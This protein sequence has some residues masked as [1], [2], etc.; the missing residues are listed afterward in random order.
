MPLFVQA[1]LIAILAGLAQMDSRIFG[2]NLIDRPLVTGSIVGLILGDFQTGIIVGA[3]LE[4]VWL[5]IVNIGGATPPDVISGGILGTAFAI[6]G[7]F[8]TETAIAVA[9]PIALLAQ[10]LG[11][12]IRIINT[13][14]NHRADVHAAKGNDKGVDR[15]LYTG[16]ILFF[17][18]ASVPVFF[19]VFFGAEAVGTLVA[20]I[21]ERILYGMRMSAGILPALGMAILMRFI[22]DKTTA[23]FLFIG[24]VMSAILGMSM[25]SISIVGAAVAYAIFRGSIRQSL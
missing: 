17:L 25:I 12:L 23:P 24:F 5:G 20:A 13:G 16:A 11:I 6:I 14:L 3:S 15:I 8:D 10:S 18:F 4:L 1:L 9:M 7:G 19:G 21:P 2:Q 22:Y